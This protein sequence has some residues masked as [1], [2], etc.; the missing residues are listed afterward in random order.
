MTNEKKIL[1][2]ANFKPGMGG[3]SVQVESLF[4]CL[5]QEKNLLVDIFSTTGSFV[6]RLIILVGL[7]FKTK[8]YD[9]VHA[10]GCSNRGF[11]PIVYGIVAGKIWRK[12][13]II[14]YHGGGAEHFF[15]K[16]PRWIK[17]WLNKA[18]ERVVLS[19]FLKEVFDK[20]NMSS[21]IIPNIV[22][23]KKDYYVEKEDICPK[24]IS[25]RHLRDLYNIP[26][27][28][29]AFAIVQKEIPDASLTILGDGDK[30]KELE[31]YVSDNYLKNICFLGQIPNEKMGEFLTKSHIM[32]SAPKEDNMPV[33]ILEA[34]SAGLLV[35]SS[36][37]GGVPYMVEHGRTGLLFE[38]DNEHDMA[39]QMLWALTHKSDSLQMIRNAK[40]E[41]EK[42]SKGMVIKHIKAL[43]E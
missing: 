16:H 41:V 13:I 6:K 26:C 34:F 7:I 4:K 21:V 29:K 14:T 23:F 35:I 1:F 5:S 3:I 28:L 2:V 27:I 37:V 32:L 15:S 24:F 10:H 20:Y 39:E 43:Y 19:G 42:Y 22:D 11:L 38:S 30:R 40:V 8:K 33:S 17:F 31:T 18:D 36:N 9:I 25:V 12:R